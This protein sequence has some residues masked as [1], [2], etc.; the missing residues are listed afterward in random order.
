MGLRG[1]LSWDLSDFG[2]GD[3]G[4]KGERTYELTH[5]RSY[6]RWTS[7][8]ESLREFGRKNFCGCMAAKRRLQWSLG[9]AGDGLRNIACAL[10]Q[11]VIIIYYLLEIRK[12]MVAG[13][14]G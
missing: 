3:R 13:E 8:Y 7:V 11:V 10:V 9:R 5:E 14:E 2:E 12:G 6:E 4:R 1:C